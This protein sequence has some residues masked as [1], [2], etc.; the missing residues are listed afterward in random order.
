MPL[1]SLRRYAPSIRFFDTLSSGNTRR[2]SGQWQIPR[3]TT[4]CAGNRSSVLPLN[5]MCPDESG[6]VRAIALSSVVLPAPFDPRTAT[7]SFGST[8]SDNRSSASALPYLT[9]RFSI[10]SKVDIFIAV[11]VSA[12]LCR[13][14]IGLDHARVPDNLGGSANRNDLAEIHG[15]DFVHK[16]H[17]FAQL[18][19]NKQNGQSF[20]LVQR[21][22]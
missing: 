4:S 10:S 2:P 20:A 19:L 3:A 8:C 12:N 21:T 16:L 5:L 15:D 17:E 18:V 14:E 11:Q 6:T 7:S 22:D 1:L 13:A 9:T